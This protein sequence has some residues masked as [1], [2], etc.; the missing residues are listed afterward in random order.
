[1]FS[2]SPGD[3]AMGTF[4][5]KAM[6]NA[7][8][9][10]DPEWLTQQAFQRTTPTPPAEMRE[11]LNGEYVEPAAGRPRAG[12]LPE[13]TEAPFISPE[14]MPQT[15]PNAGGSFEEVN[16]REYG[17]TV[18]PVGPRGEQGRVV[19]AIP[20]P[21]HVQ[22]PQVMQP[23]RLQW[24]PR[25]NGRNQLPPMSLY[26]DAT[27]PNRNA[28]EAV[29]I[30]ET[31]E[32]EAIRR[33]YEQKRLPSFLRAIQRALPEHT[34]ELVPRG[35]NAVEAETSAGSQSGTPL[36][37]FLRVGRTPIAPTET[38]PVPTFLMMPRGTQAEATVPGTSIPS[39]LRPRTAQPEAL[40]QAVS[41]H[42]GSDHAE[43][44]MKVLRES[45]MQDVAAVTEDP[46]NGKTLI[47]FNA[48]G[49][50]TTITRYADELDTPAKVH[51]I[52]AEKHGEIERADEREE[53][54]KV[55]PEL[56]LGVE[57]SAIPSAKGIGDKI[58]K[59][60]RNTK[61]QAGKMATAARKSTSGLPA[62]LSR[63]GKK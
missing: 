56:P 35:E 62:F 38:G 28:V 14:V 2:G 4:N 44:A 57:S 61:R 31:A 15:P 40:P 59:P 34:E 3:I 48:P 60:K 9:M 52:V 11:V 24:G 10:N 13:Y 45:G 17:S 23:P 30:P 16:N 19:R 43:L 20:L 37:E 27:V 55:Q 49:L 46:R 53:L 8:K 12:L 41:E 36:P 42:G 7:E 22:E 33:N 63:K 50:G 29:G 58:T 54:A 6:L 51:S 47:Q 1:V 18:I 32:A 39:F 5:T 21:E 26:P 25:V